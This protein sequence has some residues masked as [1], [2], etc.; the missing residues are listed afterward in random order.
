MT[1]IPFHNNWYSDVIVY[2]ERKKYFYM[3][4][5]KNKPL[6]DDEIRNMNLSIIDQARR[7]MQ[8]TYGD[9]GAPTNT[10]SKRGVAA[11]DAFK[12]LQSST[13]TSDNFTIRGGGG[14]E[15]PAVLFVRGFYVFLTGDIEYIDQNNLG[16]ITDA[17]FTETPIPDL[18]PPTPG[19]DR[20][21][22][23]YLDL[24]FSEASAVS[25]PNRS[26]YQDLNLKNPIVG[27]ETASRARAVFDIRVW[28]DWRFKHV[29]GSPRSPSE[30]EN[31]RIT[32]NIFNYGDFLGSVDTE[33]ETDPNPVNKNYRVPLAILY[34]RGGQHGI[35]S[36][37][38]I[39]LLDLYDKRTLSLQEL[40]YRVSHGGYTQ[41][42]VDELNLM[43]TYAGLT[44]LVT[45]RFPNAIVDESAYASGPN[46]GFGSES[47]NSGS[48]TP[49]VLDNDGKF[50][51]GGLLVGRETGLDIYP[52]TGP[53]GLMP[54]EVVAKDISAKS[55]YV[56]YDRTAPGVRGY[57]D[58]VN[59]N[60]YGLT[61]ANGLTI[62]NKTSETGTNCVHI[63]TLN[64]FI[65]VDYK[66]RL[67][68]NTE[69]PGWTGPDG[70]WETGVRFT[71]T[72]DAVNIVADINDSARVTQHLFVDKDSHVKRDSY[73]PTWK[74][75]GVLDRDNPAIFG[76]TG[77]PKY[78]ITGSSA[79][80][81][82]V[83]GIAVRG[84]TGIVEGYT[85]TYGFYESYNPDGERAYSIGSEGSNF[86]RQVQS[87]YGTSDRDLFQSDA[88]FMHLSEN[89]MDTQL[90]AGD[91]ITYNITLLD[92][93]VITRTV[94]P[95]TYGGFSG[96]S[97]VVGDINS[98]TGAGF[99]R[100]FTYEYAVSRMYGETGPI[101]YITKPGE[102]FGAAICYENPDPIDG[103]GL[104][105]LVKSMPEIDK[106]VKDVSL[107]VN[108]FAYVPD[109]LVNFSKISYYGD[110]LFG[111]DVIELRFVKFDLGEAADAFLFNGDVY[112]NGGGLLDKV[113]F[114][115][116]AIFRD[117]VYVYGKV[118]AERLMIQLAKFGSLQ[119]DRDAEISKYLSV[120]DGL[121]VG[122][123]PY[124]RDGVYVLGNTQNTAYGI[125]F[126][127]KELVN[128]GI[129]A[130]NLNLIKG[131][132]Q[133]LSDFGVVWEFVSS[134]SEYPTVY[135]IMNGTANDP[136]MPFG[137]HLKDNGN[138]LGASIN[139]FV[140]DGSDSNG[141]YFNILAWIKGDLRVGTSDSD[142][143]GAILS[144]RLT[145]GLGSSVVD[146]T[147]IL[148]LKNG[149]AYIDNLTVKSLQYDMS[150]PTSAAFF[151]NPQNIIVVQPEIGDTAYNKSNGITR[152][153]EF[154]L[155]TLTNPPAVLSNIAALG[156]PDGYDYG[157]LQL[158][159]S[160][161]V[162]AQDNLTFR[163]SLIE[164]LSASR[165]DNTITTQDF[166]VQSVTLP[167]STTPVP[168][169]Q[170]YRDNFA[171]IIVANFGA[172]KIT[173]KGYD[174]LKYTSGTGFINNERTT[175]MADFR[176]STGNL[177]DYKFSSSL[178]KSSTSGDNTFNW[179]QPINNFVTSIRAS[180]NDK[181]WADNALYNLNKV[182][183]VYI[184]PDSWKVHDYGVTP[185]DEP[186]LPPEGP[187]LFAYYERLLYYPYS[188]RI[189]NFNVAD[190][191]KQN[192]TSLIT[193]WQVAIYPRIVQQKMYNVDTQNV[194]AN[195]D[196]KIY[197]GLW[198][199][200]VVIYPNV[201]G[202]CNNLVGDLLI[203]YM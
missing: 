147:Y 197:E 88:D 6:L 4:A 84:V 154:S 138:V 141:N 83:P 73:G 173:W 146:N 186:P 168:K 100:T 86:D 98:P 196:V 9:V 116:K 59:I 169:W 171:R 66:G 176:S 42:D 35:V 27:S 118:V 167:G 29:D 20:V 200:D 160:E 7:S 153:K 112:F 17:D 120:V 99:H 8:R 104:R 159:P 87:L 177:I 148:S 52:V 95:L 202:S 137:I 126:N 94:G 18:N 110:S 85:G 109:L 102:A 38:I 117:D 79:T 57:D 163:R 165:G 162:W 107:S 191:D 50:S 180:F 127:L 1:T 128:G 68:I 97:E 19:S 31:L 45:A 125:K 34:R 152:R 72:T 65:N 61:G 183:G 93:S 142:S 115:P 184:S 67:G 122:Y 75:P 13:N 131:S 22:I 188:G 32:E 60:L 51:M 30:I 157:A 195:S 36:S 136:A 106:A 119:V 189:I 23:V 53:E 91:T 81:Q 156:M 193:Q 56:G 89:Y 194:P 49:R 12:I 82:V 76:V 64:N 78:G 145:L 101:T 108:R 155:D 199:I 3:W 41:R 40:T 170:H 21:D 132:E 2:D 201:T 71:G 54:G 16:N 182:L 150:N 90:A 151:T 14:I 10:Y 113:T 192:E 25:G 47:F 129:R 185:I 105:L 24:H 149:T 44:G 26:E 178:F 144:K 55:I 48:V 190:F 15:N 111:G 74:I 181:L 77:M 134:T 198:N 175:S 5:R 69:E 28:E 135:A 114:S 58:R 43:T 39:N 172:L 46:Y 133:D 124:A 139:T 143:T 11:N 92:E 37:D 121:V 123:G 203:S 33:M 80:V 179:D 187:Q 174:N 70:V 63:E 140:F 130:T 164:G 96:L 161:A 103:F 62:I 158:S 166:N